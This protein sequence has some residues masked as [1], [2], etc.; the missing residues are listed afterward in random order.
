MDVLNGSKP[1]QQRG[2]WSAQGLQ[3]VVL[4]CDGKL[5]QACGGLDSGVGEQQGRQQVLVVPPIGSYT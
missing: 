4:C 5:S 3:Q 2:S 1:A